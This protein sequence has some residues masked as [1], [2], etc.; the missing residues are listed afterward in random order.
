MTTP[1]FSGPSQFPGVNFCSWLS[2]FKHVFRGSAVTEKS[3]VSW[4]WRLPGCH[5]NASC[6]CLLGKA[7][8]VPDDK[9]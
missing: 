9:M 3:G 4:K 8:A 2:L 1:F 7:K 5:G 6:L